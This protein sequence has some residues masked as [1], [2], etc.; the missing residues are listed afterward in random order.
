VSRIK[1]RAKAELVLACAAVTDRLAE[2]KAVHAEQPTDETRAARRQAMA[3]VHETRA[4][5]RAKAELARLP[6]EIAV[7]SGLTDPRSVA[8]RQAAEQKL[9]R[10]ERDYG[11]LVAAMDVLAGG[12]R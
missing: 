11:D 1:E 9:A 3:V 12:G 6:R 4:W 5:L 7:L 8:K 10:I 2:A